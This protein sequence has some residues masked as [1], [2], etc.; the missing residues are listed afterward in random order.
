MARTVSEYY[1]QKP[2]YIPE[3]LVICILSHWI[4]EEEKSVELYPYLKDIDFML[5]ISKFELNRATFKT[6]DECTI[7][8]T[9]KASDNIVEKLKKFKYKVNKERVSKKRKK[10]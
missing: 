9:F 10:R 6:Q 5:L 2:A 1:S 3:F 7:A 8:D 4:L